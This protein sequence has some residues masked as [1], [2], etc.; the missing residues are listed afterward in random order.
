MNRLEADAF[1]RTKELEQGILDEYSASQQ[2]KGKTKSSDSQIRLMRDQLIMARAYTYL[3]QATNH[4]RLVH[5]LKFRIKDYQ[6]TLADC[7]LDSEL[8]RG[9]VFFLHPIIYSVHGLH[10]YH[11]F[12]CRFPRVGEN[13]FSSLHPSS[14]LM[15]SPTIH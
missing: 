9:L 13:L 12:C 10:R 5:D 14:L 6:K 4:V 2:Q 7:N 11:P 15:F 1:Q 3:A 8:P